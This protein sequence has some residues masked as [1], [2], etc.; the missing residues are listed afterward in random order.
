[1]HDRA[2][3]LGHYRDRARAAVTD[4][5]LRRYWVTG[6]GLKLRMSPFNAIVAKHAL[7]AF[8]SRMK[9][10]HACLDYFRRL[11]A[12]VRYLQPVEVA[13][14]AHMG[15]WYGFKPLYLPKMLGG[16]PKAKL[17]EIL[18]AE[19]ME[20]LDPSGPC[21]ATLPLFAEEF[22]GSIPWPH[23]PLPT[24]RLPTRWP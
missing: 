20:I 19:G 10:R 14:Y 17:V 13:P 23:R 1:M 11:L 3:L 24:I 5:Q 12:N 8:D 18:R 9:E 2:T 15:A 6:Y 7:T 4:P 16:M 21:L 22:T